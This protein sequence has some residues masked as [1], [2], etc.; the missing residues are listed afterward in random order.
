[1]TH[2]ILPV[3]VYVAYRVV[4]WLIIEA[5]QELDNTKGEKR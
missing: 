3:V 4:Y 5:G 2:A 1:M